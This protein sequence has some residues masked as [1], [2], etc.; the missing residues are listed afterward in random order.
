MLD[1]TFNVNFV[2]HKLI[3]FFNF[4]HDVDISMNEQRFMDIV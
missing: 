2:V 1:Q 4:Y 3:S